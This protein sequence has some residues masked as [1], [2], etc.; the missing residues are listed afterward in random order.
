MLIVGYISALRMAR[1]YSIIVRGR[2]RGFCFYHFESIRADHVEAS[3]WGWIPHETLL[4][5]SQLQQYMYDGVEWPTMAQSRRGCHVSIPRAIFQ[6]RWA[7]ASRK[8]IIG[9]TNN[10]RAPRHVS[11][12][13]RPRRSP[14]SHR[15]GRTI[16]EAVRRVDQVAPSV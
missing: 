9:D 6:V 12:E 14:C 4:L 13:T 8:N 7:A 10:G 11:R 3:V 16:L 1:R 5:Y 2:D 15:S